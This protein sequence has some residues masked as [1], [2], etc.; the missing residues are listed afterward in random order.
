MKSR[1]VGGVAVQVEAGG[2]GRWE[3]GFQCLCLYVLNVSFLDLDQMA[4]SCLFTNISKPRKITS[5]TLGGG[6][7]R[8]LLK[9]HWVCCAS[10][11]Q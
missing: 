11:R 6:V 8:Y 7:Q 1:G 2:S 5:I 9:A 4:W 10:G 3:A